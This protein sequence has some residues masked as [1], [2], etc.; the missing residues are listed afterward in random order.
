MC[1]TDQ[2]NLALGSVALIFILGCTKTDSSPL[3]ANQS[4]SGSQ[5]SP[6]QSIDVSPA[7]GAQCA[8]GG[9]V[10]SIYI[11]ENTNS[12]LDVGEPV[13]NAQVVC[14]GQN[15]A[16][17]ANGL[18]GTNGFS[19]LFS[20]NRVGV[21]LEACPS[22]SGL[23]V[24]S[25]LDSDRSGILEP[26][27]ISQAQILCD[28]A[29]GATGAA[30]PAG[31]DGHDLVFQAVDAAPEVCPAGG[32]TLMMALDINNL[33]SYSALDPDQQ[34]MTLCNG[35]NGQNGVDGQNG[36][37]GSNGANGQNGHDGLTPAYSPVEPILPCGNTV[38]YKEVLL[39]LSNGQVL[40]SFSDNVNGDM[41]RLVFLPDGTF[42]DTDNSNCTFSL[43]T[44][45]DGT[46]RS[47]SWAGQV[48]LSWAVLH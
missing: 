25:G 11:D 24:N 12:K 1:R 47:M 21:G 4:V 38:A 31:R 3:P 29:N 10:Y 30:G 22:G 45:V 5:S 35:L 36:K 32:K 2:M 17:G 7:T 46:S 43:A 16:N 44:S 33:G 8:A 13:L 41:T 39:R 23:Q 26:A 20:L 27:E 48:Q 34:S 19:T 14:N 15:G 18:N 28:G 9:Q 40:A 37:D 42:M 6:S